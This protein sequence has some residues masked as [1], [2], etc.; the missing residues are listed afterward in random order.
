MIKNTLVV[1][2]MLTSL[3]ACS[4]NTESNKEQTAIEYGTVDEGS[5][6]TL[7]TYMKYQLIQQRKILALKNQVKI[8]KT[9][10]MVKR[11]RPEW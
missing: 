5:M 9:E 6:V 2:A 7:N 1:V 11:C 8:Q 4:Q 3:V 10:K